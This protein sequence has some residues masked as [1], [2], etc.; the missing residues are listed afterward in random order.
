MVAY[1][2]VSLLFG[3]AVEFC[4]ASNF[5]DPALPECCCATLP[6]M[7]GGYSQRGGSRREWEVANIPIVGIV[8]LSQLTLSFQAIQSHPEIILAVSE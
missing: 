6:S 1:L 2:C 8:Y 7:D 5:I 4:V 3:E